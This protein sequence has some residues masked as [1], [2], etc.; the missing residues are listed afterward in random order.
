MVPSIDLLGLGAVA[1]DDLIFLDGF[2]EPDTKVHIVRSERQGGGLTG[3]ALVAAARLGSACVYA[4]T[5]GD[6]EES[7][8]ITDGLAGEGVETKWIVRKDGA[9]PYRSIIL[10]DMK[11][12][13]RTLLSSGEGVIGADPVLPEEPLIRSSRVLFVDHSGMEGMLRAARIARGAGIPVVADFERGHPAPYEELFALT[14]HLILPQGYALERTGRRDSRAAAEALWSPARAAVVV[15]MGAEGCWFV[16]EEDPGVPYHQPAFKVHVVDTTGCGDVFHGAYA[17]CL[18]RGLRMRERVRVASATA[19]IKA[20]RPGGQSG[21]PSLEEVE[22][23]LCDR[24]ESGL[25]ISS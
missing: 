17:S 9:R 4:G 19:A 23:F 20:T 5:L 15:T 6:D 21:I 7:R 22:A 10:V 8:F 25:P 16:S 2:P 11:T 13:T 24:S 1:V 12:G 3:T 14:N 18:A